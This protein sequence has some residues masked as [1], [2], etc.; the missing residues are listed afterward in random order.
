MGWEALPDELLD[1]VLRSAALREARRL[2][3]VCRRALVLSGVTG[4]S[5]IAAASASAA[6]LRLSSA[7]AP[8]RVG[9]GKHRFE[10]GRHEA[11]ATPRTAAEFLSVAD[12]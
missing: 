6:T 12:A 10:D 7:P 2:C 11:C 9:T 1:H 8:F 5:S 4:Q 3:G